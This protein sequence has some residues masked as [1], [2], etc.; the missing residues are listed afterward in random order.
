MMGIC[1]GR[2]RRFL[3]RKWGW[4]TVSFVLPM[5]DSITH[6][7]TDTHSTL[8][9][10][11]AAV[12]IIYSGDIYLCTDKSSSS[13]TGGNVLELVEDTASSWEQWWWSN[14]MHCLITNLIRKEAR[15]KKKFSQK[16]NWNDVK[17]LRSG[18]SH[19]ETGERGKKVAKFGKKS[20][21]NGFRTMSFFNRPHQQQYTDT[22]SD[23]QYQ[24]TAN[25]A[26]PHTCGT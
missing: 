21:N 16:W 19:L 15:E 3:E 17:Y 22:N 6:T 1:S 2:R 18:N 20:R 4:P 25:N 14:L 26:H 9:L 7:H 13:S 12:A 24:C 8:A 23:H 10:W 5:Q 11:Q